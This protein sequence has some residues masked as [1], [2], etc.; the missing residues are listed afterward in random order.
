V[1][2]CRWH[3]YSQLRELSFYGKLWPWKKPLWDQD[4][5]DLKKRIAKVVG[6]KVVPVASSGYMS[7]G[8][9]VWVDE[10]GRYYATNREEMIFIGSSI[11]ALLE[12]LL[13]EAPLSEPPPELKDKLIKGYEGIDE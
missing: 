3:V 6:S 1:G 10:G 9:V 2:S 8:C 13:G 5:I 4:L 12:V 11:A 7:E